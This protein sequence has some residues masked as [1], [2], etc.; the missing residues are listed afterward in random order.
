MQK[1]ILGTGV[2]EKLKLSKNHDGMVIDDVE[3]MGRIF[4]VS[5]DGSTY[6]VDDT[7]LVSVNETRYFVR[8]QYSV[9]TMDYSKTMR[10]QEVVVNIIDSK[11]VICL[12][13]GDESLLESIK[14]KIGV[15]DS[16]LILDLHSI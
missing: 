15:L 11:I 1:F 2:S 13:F 3:D 12:D 10:G 14:E 7:D 5:I 6:Y 9:T 16:V 4:R 8:Y